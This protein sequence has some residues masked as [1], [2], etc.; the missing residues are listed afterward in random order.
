RSSVEEGYWSESSRIQKVRTT[1]SASGQGDRETDSQGQSNPGSR[2]RDHRY[3]RGRAFEKGRP[4]HRSV[5]LRSAT[6]QESCPRVGPRRRGRSGRKGG[7]TIQDGGPDRRVPRRSSLPS[8]SGPKSPACAAP[9]I[10]T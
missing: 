10:W 8:I 5:I 4:I 2:L 7:A 3:L 6:A 1:G 9:R